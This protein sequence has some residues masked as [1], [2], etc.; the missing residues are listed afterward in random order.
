MNIARAK[1]SISQQ[2][3]YRPK[4]HDCTSL[5]LY[6][7][8]VWD[9]E[10]WLFT[11]NQV[12]EVFLPG[13]SSIICLT[14]MQTSNTLIFKVLLFGRVGISEDQ[15]SILSTVR[16]STLQFFAHLP[17]PSTNL[18]YRSFEP[19]L[20]FKLSC[21]ISKWSNSSNGFA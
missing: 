1:Q 21:L 8:S 14:D 18:L 16:Y 12:L 7:G 13:S 15:T 3:C 10:F 11:R 2:D 5:S 6:T 19:T 9:T 17:C 4:A 20:V